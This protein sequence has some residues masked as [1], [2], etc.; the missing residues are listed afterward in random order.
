MYPRQEFHNRDPSLVR[1]RRGEAC[2]RRGTLHATSASRSAM[3][4]RFDFYLQP[5]RYNSVAWSQA[6]NGDP[7]VCVTGNPQIKVFN[8]KTG[9]LE[10]V[11]AQ[12]QDCAAST[13]KL[14]H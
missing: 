14:R 12:Y 1:E 11:C 7:L 13:N 4:N 9:E 10:A 5:L 6:E 2:R 3:A 8:V